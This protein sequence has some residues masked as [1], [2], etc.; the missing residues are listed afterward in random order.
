MDIKEENEFKI[1][2]KVDDK[3]I[4]NKQNEYE[5][6]KIKGLKDMMNLEFFGVLE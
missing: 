6:K 4:L 3:E 2:D 5:E 1:S